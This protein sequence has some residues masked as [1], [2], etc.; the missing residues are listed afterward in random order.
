MKYWL[1]IIT[2]SFKAY[3]C[4][5]II[6]ELQALQSTVTPLP[7]PILQFVRLDKKSMQYDY[8]HPYGAMIIKH[9]EEFL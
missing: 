7:P 8:W 4:D 3:P 6:T 2:Y 9:S 5:E 1:N